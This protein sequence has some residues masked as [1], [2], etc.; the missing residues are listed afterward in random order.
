MM[1]VGILVLKVSVDKLIKKINCLSRNWC[2][3]KFGLAAILV[4]ITTSLPE[5]FVA[6]SAALKKIPGLAVGN[7][8]GVNMINISIE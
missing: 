1:G 7:A 8:L 3:G 6:V 5:V 4:G 2:I